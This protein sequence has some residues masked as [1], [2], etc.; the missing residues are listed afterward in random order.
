MGIATARAER[1]EFLKQ[2]AAQV[3]DMAVVADDLHRMIGQ[4]GYARSLKR[5]VSE[6]EL[7][8]KAAENMARLGYQFDRAME[9][10]DALKR[11]GLNPNK[12]AELLKLADTLKDVFDK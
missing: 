6:L 10:A 3:K 12:V 1:D 5:M 4:A 11:S 7:L 9:A 2:A 8:N